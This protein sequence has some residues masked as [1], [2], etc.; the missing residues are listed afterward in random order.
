MVL[1]TSFLNNF[2]FWGLIFV[3]M[4]DNWVVYGQLC[5]ANDIN[6]HVS[7]RAG[8]GTNKKKN[9]HSKSVAVLHDD[10]LQLLQHT[11]H[12][13]ETKPTS[14]TFWEVKPQQIKNY[15]H[16]EDEFIR[17]TNRP[18]IVR[19]A[20]HK[21]GAWLRRHSINSLESMVNAYADAPLHI[22]VQSLEFP[23]ETATLRGFHAYIQSNA[24]AKA[25]V[26]SAI[27]DSERWITRL[28]LF[29]KKETQVTPRNQ[30]KFDRVF[31]FEDFPMP[32]YFQDEF[33]VYEAAR[34]PE[35]QRQVWHVA[36]I[37]NK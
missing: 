5:N 36:N 30:S 27:F 3:N 33:T 25:K 6:C 35:L 34:K 31:F 37:T 7:D 21:L 4:L 18:I 14:C 20:V 28:K 13:I 26:P 1:L 23:E 19:N 22:A 17:K 2:C 10:A 8:S 9:I 15:S 29:Q 12:G 24:A 11:D 32:Y 16:F